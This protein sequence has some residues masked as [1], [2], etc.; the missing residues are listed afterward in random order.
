MPQPPLE[1][2]KIGELAART[3]RSVHAIR[4]YESQGLLPGV[5]R[6]AAGRRVYNEQHQGWL[7]LM[8]R[9]RKTGMT[10][11]QMRDY[12]AL[13]MQGKATLRQR[14]QLLAA[15]RAHIAATLAQW[16]QAQA[17][18]DSKIEFY[19]QWMAS[20]QRPKLVRPNP[21]PKA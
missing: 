4:W 19:G 18:I 20:G 8:E 5:A 3:G 9:L 1:H 2:Y 14:Q 13:V 15:H 6:D 10:I 17:L 16:Q 7:E 12:T 11:A 21:P